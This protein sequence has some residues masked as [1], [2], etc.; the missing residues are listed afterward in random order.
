[1]SNT[2]KA[3]LIIAPLFL[4]SVQDRKAWWK[5]ENHLRKL[6]NSK[7]I[8]K[9]MVKIPK[10]P[11]APWIATQSPVEKPR[12]ARD[13]NSFSNC[14]K[15][16]SPQSWETM[17]FSRKMNIFHLPIVNSQRWNFWSKTI[18]QELILP[19]KKA[20]LPWYIVSYNSISRQYYT[21]TAVGQVNILEV[22]SCSDQ[23]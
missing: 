18:K 22:A 3:W 8:R 6:K 17:V 16:C 19:R 4:S 1:M 14:V 9:S 21:V 15:K 11:F 5:C 7:F 10:L 20:C 23:H 12:M 13:R 2:F